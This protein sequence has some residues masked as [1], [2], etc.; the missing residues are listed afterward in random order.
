MENFSV[1]E[2][3]KILADIFVS[4]PF[5]LCLAVS[6]ILTLVCISVCAIYNKKLNRWIYISFWSFFLVLIIAIYKDIFLLLIDSLFEKFFM[7]L[8]FPSL[9]VYVSVIVISNLFFIYSLLKKN[10]NYLH[11]ILNIITSII[12]NVFFILIVDIVDK[13]N[14]NVYEQIAVFSNSNLLVLLELS[15]A[16]FLSWILLNLL[17][18]ANIKLKKYDKKEYPKMQEIIFE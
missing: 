11:K 6:T 4:S 3:L 16:V 13:N 9:T 2:K 1:M 5:F 15:T 18:T 10:I 12:I 14:I 17:I 8:Y 7:A